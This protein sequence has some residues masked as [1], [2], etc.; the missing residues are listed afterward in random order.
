MAFSLHTLARR[1][2]EVRSTSS[3]I[4]RG[5]RTLDCPLFPRTLERMS[6]RE[7]ASCEAYCEEEE[8]GCERKTEEGTKSIAWHSFLA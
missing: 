2:R 4:A 7:E 6:R 1:E 8:E 3:S 5:R